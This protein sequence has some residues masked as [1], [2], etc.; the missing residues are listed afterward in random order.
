MQTLHLGPEELLVAAKVGVPGRRPRPRSPQA[1]DAAEERIRAAVPIARVIY[2]EPDIYQATADD[3][4]RDRPRGDEPRSARTP[5]V[6]GPRSPRCRA[7]RRRPPSRRRSCG[8]ARTRPPRPRARTGCRW[9]TLIAADPA[10]LLGASTCE[11]FGPRLPFLLKV[12]AAA[13]P[14]SLQAHPDAAQAPGGLRGAADPAQ[15]RRPVPQA[16]A[17]GGADRVRGA[18][19]LPRPGRARPTSWPRSAC[20]SSARSIDVLRRHQGRAAGRGRAALLGE[21]AGARPTWSW[22]P[23]AARRRRVRARRRARPSSTRA[24]PASSSPCCSTRSG[25]APARRS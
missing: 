10:A 24:T 6:R 23:A 17:A 4:A 8:W 25:C 20:P 21:P 3:V 12:L 7:A 22:R 9:P 2:I 11:R 14:L 19:R 18:V 15:L 1:I 16:G 5:G 13:E